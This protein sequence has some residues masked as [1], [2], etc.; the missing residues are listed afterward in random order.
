MCQEKIQN[1]L[2]IFLKR[3]IKARK[4][5][6]FSQRELASLVGISYQTVNRYEKGH[7]IPDVGYVLK[8]ANALDVDSNWL[9][10][11]EGEMFKPEQPETPRKETNDICVNAIIQKLLVLEEDDKLDILLHVENVINT[12]TVF[13]EN[14]VDPDNVLYLKDHYKYKNTYE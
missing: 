12:R 7:R 6:G 14:P 5:K 4:D 10:T 1:I 2:N 11:G 3:I 9:L 13:G 8:L